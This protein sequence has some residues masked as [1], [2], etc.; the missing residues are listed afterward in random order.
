LLTGSSH[1]TLARCASTAPLRGSMSA[2]SE[3]PS[4]RTSLSTIGQ[5]GQDRHDDSPTRPR[6]RWSCTRTPDSIL[7]RRLGPAEDATYASGGWWRRPR[8][9]ARQ[10]RLNCTN[11][12]LATSLDQARSFAVCRAA[13]RCSWAWTDAETARTRSPKNGTPVLLVSD[14]TD[15]VLPGADTAQSSAGISS[16]GQ[17]GHCY[18]HD[19][20]FWSLPG[21]FRTW[22]ARR[23]RLGCHCGL[24]PAP[25][26]TRSRT[27]AE[28]MDNAVQFGSSSRSF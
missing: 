12:R 23:Y 5:P 1:R 6:R 7:V 3:I 16:Q 24:S 2:D 19:R 18:G 20:T 15:S 26:L 8:A 11:G 17:I 21:T 28:A 9:A 22:S 25:R 14:F 10:V 13:L 4:G 27:R